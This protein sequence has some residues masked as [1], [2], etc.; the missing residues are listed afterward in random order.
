[1]LGLVAVDHDHRRI[2]PTLMCITQA[3]A[4]A[5]NQR[6]RM[7]RHGTLQFARQFRR[8]EVAARRPIRT[9]DGR[10]Q[11][12]DGSPV[13]RRERDALGEV[14][15]RQ[16]PLQLVTD[17]LA[18]IRAQSVP[19]VDNDDERAA[20][21][22]D[23]AEQAHVLL[24]DTL[25]GI[26]HRDDDLGLIDGL[27]RL[28]DTELLDRFVH[29]RPASDAGRVD[30]CVLAIVLL[31]RDRDAVPGRTRLIEDHETLLADDPV[32]ER[33]LAHVRPADDRDPQSMLVV[34]I[35]RNCLVGLVCFEAF[36]YCLQQ[37]LDVIAVRRRDGYRIAE[38]ERME[39][40]RRDRGIESLGLVDDDQC[41]SRVTA[42]ELGNVFVRGSQ[43][44]AGVDHDEGD[45]GFREGADGL[46]RRMFV[47]AGLAASDAT[48]VDDQEGNGTDLAEPVLP[49]PRQT[50]VVRDE[51][52]TRS[53]QP[54]E[55][56]RLA[57]VRAADQSDYG[58]HCSPPCAVAQAPLSAVSG[59]LRS[60]L[61][62]C[63][64]TNAATVP[65]SLCTYRRFATTIG[66][67]EIA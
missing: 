13:Q 12:A 49:V 30:Q 53:R 38:A 42:R 54:V 67:A 48:R 36:E 25:V 1:M 39:F 2:A 4:P 66:S 10:Q 18:R 7:G 31:E 58:Q 22:Q 62:G 33:R 19:L 50:R 11:I 43:A 6:R 14:E 32:D 52:V 51:R 3:D 41:T 8:R 56:R 23:Q 46:S 55:Q 20:P 40:A 5:A 35:R 16:A 9:F 34:V 24:G 37:R 65:E 21:L 63:S 60:L 26:E 17:V 57:D 29:A 27:Q 47:D 45:I 59:A 61:L 15:E 44:L 28:D 64:T